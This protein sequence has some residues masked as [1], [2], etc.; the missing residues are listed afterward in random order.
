MSNKTKCPISG[1]E[2]DIPRNVHYAVLDEKNSHIKRL[3]A[4]IRALLTNIDIEGLLLHIRKG[5]TAEGLL[6]TE[7]DALRARVARL[8]EALNGVLPPEHGEYG[9]PLVD[10]V[11][12]YE[13]GS[14]TG[15]ITPMLAKMHIRHEAVAR[16]RRALEEE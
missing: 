2:E 4:A 3:E 10:M 14:P 6:E 12:R 1:I 7:R 15:R 8:E 5:T 13:D 16:A 11:A 9:G